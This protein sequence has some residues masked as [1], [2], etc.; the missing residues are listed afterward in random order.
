MEL[1]TVPSSFLRLS[2]GY[3]L[4]FSVKMMGVSAIE[5]HSTAI[6]VTMGFSSTRI[7]FFQ[8][9]NSVIAPIG[10]TCCVLWIDQTGRRWPLTIGNVVNESNFVLGSILMARWPGTVDNAAHYVRLTFVSLDPTT[11]HYQ[12]AGTNRFSLVRTAPSTFASP[13]GVRLLNTSDL[14]LRLRCSTFS[15]ARVLDHC[16]GLIQWRY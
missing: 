12:I 6:F 5:Y 9:I 2:L 1:I 10:E 16:R 15:S 11:D 13:V 4:Q 8:F 14:Q 7:L 3:V